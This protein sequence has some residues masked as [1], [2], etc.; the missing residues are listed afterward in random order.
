MKR[1]FYIFL[2]FISVFFKLLLN[3]TKAMYLSFLVAI[4]VFLILLY[5]GF[6]KLSYGFVVFCI[7]AAIIYFI[8]QAKK[9]WLAIKGNEII[10]AKVN[11]FESKKRSSRNTGVYYIQLMDY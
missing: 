7:F 2:F 10:I 11:K 4:P 1:I 5:N 8:M 6:E 9:Y 3:K